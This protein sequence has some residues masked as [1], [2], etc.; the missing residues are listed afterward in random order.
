MGARRG[1]VLHPRPDTR[2]LSSSRG[3]AGWRV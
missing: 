1:P 3:V 2:H